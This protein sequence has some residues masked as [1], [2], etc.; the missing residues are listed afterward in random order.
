M[1]QSP[2]GLRQLQER[3]Q[4]GREV[5]AA[6]QAAPEPGAGV[7]PRQRGA[8]P[9]GRLTETAPQIMTCS[10]ADHRVNIKTDAMTA[11]QK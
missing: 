1:C 9:R 8:A 3:R 11:L 7:R 6:L 5:P 4:P 10:A 2:P